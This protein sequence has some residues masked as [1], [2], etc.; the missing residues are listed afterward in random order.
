MARLDAMFTV[1]PP[2]DLML[3]KVERRRVESGGLDERVDLMMAELRRLVSPLGLEPTELLVTDSTPADEVARIETALQ[4]MPPFARKRA[5]SL[6]DSIK[7][8]LAAIDV[9]LRPKGGRQ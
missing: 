5:Q 9:R 6:S 2:T 8:D 4:S 7:A 1:P 3:A